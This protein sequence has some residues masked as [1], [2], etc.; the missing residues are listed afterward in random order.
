[1][2][3]KIFKLRPSVTSTGALGKV[4]DKKNLR[5][6]CLNRT[7]NFVLFY[8]FKNRRGFTPSLEIFANNLGWLDMGEPQ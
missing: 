5:D 7:V 3:G 2:P 6:E 8:D 1:M 4:F